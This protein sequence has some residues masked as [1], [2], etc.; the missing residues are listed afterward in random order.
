LHRARDPIQRSFHFSVILRHPT[1]GDKPDRPAPRPDP[2]ACCGERAAPGG[3]GANRWHRGGAD[4]GGLRLAPHL[5][6][7]HAEI[8][9]TVAAIR[10]YVAT[11]V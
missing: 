5:Y 10:R 11:G 9:K 7:L 4:R 3:A 6:N 1:A 2:A 8:E